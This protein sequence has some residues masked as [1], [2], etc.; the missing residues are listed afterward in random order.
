MQLTRSA[1]TSIEDMPLR[2]FVKAI[3]TND[4]DWLICD[5]KWYLPKPNLENVWEQ[6]FQQ[7]IERTKDP[8]SNKIF[9]LVRDITVIGNYINLSSQAIIVISKAQ[10]LEAL[11]GIKTALRSMLL[12]RCQFT[13]ETIDQDIKTCISGIKK[14]RLRLGELN[15]EYEELHKDEKQKVVE[16]D[17]TD[18]IVRLEKIHGVSI[19][20]K[21]ISVSKYI[22]Y[23]AEAKNEKN[24]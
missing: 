3:T 5:K 8:K 21:K 12:V 20:Y 22:S 17:F 1:Y 23:L 14:M 13:K 7:Y 10:N 6:L 11:E 2:N 24:G 18:N 4:M 15:R 16:A 19:D 9:Q